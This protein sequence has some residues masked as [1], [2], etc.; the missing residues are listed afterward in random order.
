MC[1]KDIAPALPARRGARRSL[2]A[3]T[4]A[5]IGRHIAE[6]FENEEVASRPGVLQRVEPRARLLFLVMVAVT[7]SL[8]H[9]LALLA[10]LALVDVCLAAA[11]RVS[12]RSYLA[13]VWGSAGVLALILAA[14]ATTRLVTPGRIVVE[15]GA[16]S[17]TAPGL[18][19]AATLVLRVVASAG[20]ALLVVWTMRWSDI[21][22]ALSSL[23]IPDVVIATLAMTQQQIMSLLRTVENMHLARE[24]RTLS[25]GTARENR[26]WVTGRMAFVIGK[27]IRRA[28]D[29]YDAMLARGFSGTVRTVRRL[30]SDAASWVVLSAGAAF[31]VLIVLADRLMAR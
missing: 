13:K 18:L 1:E 22:S 2:A 23:R 7:V 31:C 10:A 20:V 19:G 16:L 26:E 17:L 12:V 24:S 8:V 9:S 30:E 11:C 29:V 15:L 5:S 3:R 6:V 4:A 21:L 27:S 28:D 14:P 25:H